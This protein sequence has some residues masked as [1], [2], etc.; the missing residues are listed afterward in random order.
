MPTDTITCYM[1]GVILD[2][3]V[4]HF[5]DQKHWFYEDGGLNES[6]AGVNGGHVAGKRPCPVCRADLYSNDPR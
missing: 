2:A 4:F 6:A 1:C 5:P 3:S